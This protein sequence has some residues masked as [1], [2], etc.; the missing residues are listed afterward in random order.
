MTNQSEHLNEHSRFERVLRKFADV[1]PREGATCLILLGNI[2]L[3]LVAFYLIKPV[4]EGWLAVTD[5][6]GLTKLEIKAYSA[7]AQ[8]LLLVAILPLAPSETLAT[9]SESSVLRRSV[10]LDVE[11]V[12]DATPLSRANTPLSR[13]IS[14]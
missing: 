12:D 9:L 6:G 14:H 8:S 2:F 11:I 4:R 10:S 13:S 3:I 5:I 7:F 1:R